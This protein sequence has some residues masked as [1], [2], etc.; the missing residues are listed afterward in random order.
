MDTAKPPFFNDLDASCIHAW[1]L[2]TRAVP[3]RRSGFHMPVIT[4]IGLDGAPCGRTVVLRHVDEASR[5]IRFHTDIRASKIA[6]LTR[7]PRIG[8]VFYDFKSKLQL[9][10]NGVASIH[11]PG[12]ALALECWERSQEMSR[13][14]YAQAQAPRAALSDPF[15]GDARGSGGVEY[16]SVV[17]IEVQKLEWLYLHHEGHRRAIFEWRDGAWSKQWVAP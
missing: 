15:E 3:D 14:C 8:A 10:A 4:T 13:L 11:A 17:V 1:R 9:R 16:F 6:E 7:E 12:S 2:L 5:I